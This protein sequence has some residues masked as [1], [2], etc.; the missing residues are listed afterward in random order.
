MPMHHLLPLQKYRMPLVK[1]PF[2]F[3]VTSRGC[4]AGCN[5]CIKHV[6]Y[7]PTIR[8]R[9]AAKLVEEVAELTGSESATCTCSRTSSP[10]TARRSSISATG[11][12][13]RGSASRW[14]CN[15]RVDFVD[16]ELLALMSRPAAGASRGA[17]NRAARRSSRAP[18]RASARAHRESL[19][20]S[21]KPACS[22]GATSSSACPA[23]PRRRSSETIAFSKSLPLDI[24]L[25]HVAAPYPGTPFFEEVAKNGWFRAG[26]R[27]EDVNM[28]ESTVIDYP[29]L[30]AER[31]EY[32]Q[33]RAFR[34]WALRPRP[35]MTYARM[36]LTDV[37]TMRSAIDIG[38]QHLTWRRGHQKTR[39]AG[40]GG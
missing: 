38:L 28:D 35:M 18:T 30:P 7:G 23:R 13:S 10:T 12:C 37:R 8:L 19:R 6:S 15:S 14:T 1:G 16:K 40:A 9:S 39:A 27:W 17:S 5:S 25:F 36:L 32:W 33:K 11:C 20:W 3:I 2:S 34:E 31:L 22:T 24:A 4:P 26:V 29:H 21:T